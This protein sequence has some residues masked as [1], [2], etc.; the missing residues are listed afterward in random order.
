MS[1]SRTVLVV[2]DGTEYTEA[3]RRLSEGAVEG[4]VTFLRAADGQEARR[5]VAEQP[6]DAVFLDVVFDRT[7]PDRLAGD[8]PALKSR[9]GGDR[10]RALRHLAES[11]GFYLFQ[12]LSPL[13]PDSVPVV[14][15][16]DFS[17]EPD[18]LTELRRKRERL[19]GV[20]DG[21]PISEVLRL[22]VGESKAPESGVLRAR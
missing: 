11:Q 3:F 6:I 8:L 15:A 13:I 14:I 16:Y 22:L 1:R 21:T 4:P 5:L 20:P 2:E 19:S 9:F 12:E 7:A 17:A 18:R 10:S